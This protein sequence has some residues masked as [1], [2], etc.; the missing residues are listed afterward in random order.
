MLALLLS[1]VI[2]TVSLKVAFFLT[3]NCLVIV[4]GPSNCES[5]NP[6]VPPSTNILSLTVISSNATLNL[7]GSCPVI[8]GFGISYEIVCPLAEDTLVFPLNVSPL[9]FIPVYNAA[10]HDLS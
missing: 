8:V 6:E 5:T 9:L 2:L 10:P 1:P 3:L 7:D 4:T